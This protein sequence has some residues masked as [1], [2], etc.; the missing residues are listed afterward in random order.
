MS[1]RGL[2]ERW[3]EFIN[4][5]QQILR[6]YKLNF[7]KKLQNLLNIFQKVAMRF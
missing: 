4:D 7:G 5:Y 6:E 2:E 3:M 1:F